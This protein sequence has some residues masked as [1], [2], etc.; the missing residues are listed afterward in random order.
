MTATVQTDGSLDIQEE[1][2][3]TFEGDYSLI[4]Y[5]FDP[6]QGGSYELAGVW[7]QPDGGEK[8]AL[9]QVGFET[10]WRDE[11]G[12]APGHFALDDPRDTVY[13]FADYGDKG[14]LTLSYRYTDAIDVYTDVAEL[15]WKFIPEGWSIDTSNAT[16]S[17]ALPSPT[18]STVEPGET[19]RAWGHG[20]LD[21]DVSIGADGSVRY[22]VPKVE[23]GTF[24]EA[25]IVFP[26]SWVPDVD[27]G[28]VHDR[29]ALD[30]ILEEEQENAREANKRRIL[31]RLMYLLPAGLSLALVIASIV[32]YL[33]YGREHEPVFQEKYWRDVPDKDLHPAVVGY[34]Y[35]FGK[36]DPKD[37]PATLMYLGAKGVV[38]IEH[39]S[40]EIPRA[41]G[42]G[43]KT[44]ED[45]VLR[46]TGKG[47]EG[48]DELSRYA[49]ELIFEKLAKGEDEISLERI[50]EISHD[51]LRNFA[52]R[53]ERWDNR[54][55]YEAGKGGFF[56]T[57]SESVAGVVKALAISY[58]VLLLIAG[59]FFSGYGALGF[60]L[61]TAI[62]AAI[63]S[64]LIS[65]KITR[66]TQEGAEVAARCRALRA[67]FKDFTNLKESTPIEVK[68]WGE[69]LVYAFLFGVAD[70]VIEALRIMQPHLWDD[71]HFS[72]T[73]IWYHPAFD[74]G[75][76]FRSST[77]AAMSNARMSIGEAV[78][79]IMSSS[80]DGSGG[81]GGFSGGGGGGFGGGGGGFG[82]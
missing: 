69:L 39:V 55:S 23:D 21:G 75:I 25:R 42:L 73:L 51:D 36:P 52:V 32:L 68:V 2:T 74:D 78:R 60:G 62:P 3:F 54:V 11:G 22:T 48:L 14:T 27:A 81:G 38:E 4:G 30:G 13:C 26:T 76:G 19:V 1:R 20:S 57:K 9:T 40:S 66:R 50:R 64:F 41:L 65:T 24:A 61:M 58:P 49:L 72:S 12:P 7:Y 34:I 56:D 18:G 31:V 28:K 44:V 53:M 10:R 16:L 46:R 67:W 71:P 47:E 77:D 63:V 6:P 79:T 45:H 33:V 59:I 8:T 15:Y 17:V 70:E 80:S 43:T 5:I 29:P 35:R 37:L 82:R